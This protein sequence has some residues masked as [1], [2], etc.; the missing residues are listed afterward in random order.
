MKNHTILYLYLIFLFFLIQ[1]F[2]TKAQVNSYPYSESFESGWGDWINVGGDDKNWSRNEGITSSSSPTSIVTGP[3]GAYDGTWYIYTE[4]SGSGSGFPDKE[5]YLECDFD[6]SS[7]S[8]PVFIFYYNMNGS[9]MGSLHVDVSTDG[10]SSWDLNVWE[11]SGEQGGPTDWD[12]ANIFL[13]S[14]TGQTIKI[15]LRGITGDGYRSDMA[16]DYILL[17][18]IASNYWTGAINT[19]WDNAGNWSDGVVPDATSD[20]LIPGGKPRYPVL[21]TDANVKKLLI[22]SGAT[23]SGASYT[24]NVYGDWVNYGVFYPNSGTVKFKGSD[25]SF[26]QYYE[27]STS[28]IIN[29]DFEDG[30]AD[31]WILESLSGHTEWRVQNGDAANGSYALA[32]Y[33]LN[34]GI[35]HSFCRSSTCGSTYINATYYV[36]LR[37]YKNPELTFNWKN[38]TRGDCYAPAFMGG[39]EICSWTELYN[40]NSWNSKTIDLSEFEGGVHPLMFRFFLGNNNK[41]NPGGLHLDD[42]KITGYSIVE[43]FY[44]IVIE[45][46]GSA[47]VT[48]SS[49]LEVENDLTISANNTLD[50]NGNRILCRGDW[51]NNG[52]FV[53]HGNFTLFESNT[54]QTIKGSGNTTFYDFEKDNSQDLIIGDNTTSG[55]KVEITN[56]FTWSYNNDRIIIGNGLPTTFKVNSDLI[57][58]DLC[59]VILQDNSTLSV[60]ENYAEYG[61]SDLTGGEIKFHGAANS[62]VENS[63]TNIIF[64]EDFETDPSSNG[65]TLGGPV[66]R[67]VWEWASGKQ[68]EGSYDCAIMDN[69]STDWSYDYPWDKAGD[70]DLTTTID[71]SG[72]SNA[73]LTFYYRC[74]GNDNDFGQVLIDGVIVADS[75]SN[76]LTYA[77]HPS[78][79][80]NEY[81]DGGTHTLTFRFHFENTG[82]DVSPGFCVDNI[83][84]SA[85]SETP[86]TYYDLTVDKDN[87]TQAV[88]LQAPST[89][90]NDVNLNKGILDAGGNNIYI[91]GDWNTV[92]GAIFEPRGDTVAFEGATNQNVDIATTSFDNLDVNM[93]SG[94]LNISGNDLDVD[95]KLTIYSGNTL[96]TNGFNVYIAGDWHNEGTYTHNNNT[97]YFDG[98]TSLQTNGTGSG[99]TFYNLELDGSGIAL[100]NDLKVEGNISIIKGVL[101]ASPS[102]HN[103]YI[104]RNWTND[105]LFQGESGTVSFEGNSNSTVQGTPIELN[106]QYTEGF[107]TNFGTWSNNSGD[108]DINWTRHTGLVPSASTSFIAT[109]PDGAFENS[110]YIFTESS[111]NY[112]KEAYLDASFD[113]SA[114]NK[115]ILTFYYC[116]NG[117]HMGSLHIDVYDGSTWH[118]NL[119]QKS[120]DL[121]LTWYKAIV[122]LSDYAGSTITLRIRGVTGDGYRSDMAL[123]YIQLYDGSNVDNL[124]SF[125]NLTVNKTSSDAILQLSSDIEVSNNLNFAM[126]DIDL[127]GFDIDLGSSGI[128]VSE[129]PTNRIFQSTGDGV[130]VRSED[131]NAPT[132]DNPGNI[133]VEITSSE[134]LGTTVIRR[135]HQQQES[136]L[137]NKGIERYFDIS[138]TNN[139]GLD[140][141]TRFYYFD[142]ENVNGQTETNFILWRSTDGGVTWEGQGDFWNYTWDFTNNYIEK[143]S[144]DAFSRWTISDRQ[145]HPLPI[146]LIEFKADCNGSEIILQWKTASEINNDYFAIEKS[147]DGI[148]FENIGMVQGAGNSN[149]VLDYK[150]SDA[151]NGTIS[152]YR[153]RQVDFDGKFTLYD[154]ISVQCNNDDNMALNAYYINSHQKLMIEYQSNQ[155][156]N[157]FISIY[158]M[159]GQLIYT[160]GKTA[161]EGNNIFEIPINNGLSEGIYIARVQTNYNTKHTRF[162]VRQ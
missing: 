158:D 48:M 68:Y 35:D 98:Y 42:I 69:Y 72:Y 10:G 95:R 123:D 7:L 78:I 84:I 1:P 33:N 31:G 118:Y 3:D 88:Y 152:Y 149:E 13:G 147:Y 106:L 109:G 54:I 128:L 108:D 117:I 140:A 155:K 45:K 62:T 20:A 132:A 50:A 160:Q 27:E 127:A 94:S 29:E 148:L 26:I 142:A 41:W 12:E 32:P 110:Y 28:D 136:A 67:A 125:Y 141:T 77:K 55:I 85:S 116:M 74:G 23:L 40:N 151:Y 53:P 130:I 91:S 16:V 102:N 115:P 120:G 111:G 126:G 89:V 6:L 150:Y 100:E 129:T 107:E 71:L 143:T 104:H 154:P 86:I 138:P 92:A 73:K 113:L 97:T 61:T 4:A 139:S 137:G 47:T 22:A 5:F 46:T 134:N 15:R 56:D 2:L 63:W 90:L 80:L 76:Q 103:I 144:I 112:E 70:V 30:T 18:E 11:R 135:G 114:Y 24:L 38:R 161:L 122:D 82:G 37:N 159:Q 79:S 44:D 105:F 65:W 60:E 52:T 162:F 34:A 119:W 131:L 9:H 51:I 75:L 66:N 121:G 58:E 49:P 157:V 39:V 57:V 81:C 99:K 36:D 17:E 19:D 156:D 145:D 14:Y 59:G 87:N 96:N 146:E 8:N 43:T 133:G 25:D 101:D 83:V 124:E 153:I 64:E 93:T 21:N